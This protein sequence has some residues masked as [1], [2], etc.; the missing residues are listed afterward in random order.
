MDDDAWEDDDELLST[1]ALNTFLLALIHTQTNR[2]PGI[3]TN[4]RGSITA[5]WTQVGNRLTIECLPS[6]KASLLLTRIT[7]D[8]EVERAAFGPLH[9]SRICGVLAPFDPEIWFD[10]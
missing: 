3:G 6:G 5:A 1:E 10:S 7:D 8:G 9:P 4:G 2:R